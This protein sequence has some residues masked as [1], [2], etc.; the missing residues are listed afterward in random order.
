MTEFPSNKFNQPSHRFR[1]FRDYQAGQ[2]S[3]HLDMP[4]LFFKLQRIK[5]KE[6]LERSQG[7]GGGD[8]TLH[9]E[10]QR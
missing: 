9:I 4:L 3:K 5:T 2:I 7:Q 8:D 1:K 10:E 6:N